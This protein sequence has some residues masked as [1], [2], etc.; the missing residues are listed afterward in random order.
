MHT[1]QSSKIAQL[2]AQSRGLIRGARTAVLST[3]M[4]SSQAPFGSLVLCATGPDGAPVL[5]LS[6]LAVHTLNLE[7]DPRACLLYDATGA[8]QAPL[9]GARLS[10]MGAIRP[11]PPDSLKFDKNRF[12]ARHPSAATYADFA[13]F[14]FYRMQPDRGH[15][16]AGFGQIGWVE[17]ADLLLKSDVWD[18]L[19]PAEA[20][21]LAHMN[22]DH[23]DSIALYAQKLLGQ[24]PGP[25]RMSGCDPE[26]CDLEMQGAF[27]RLAFGALVQ[28]PARARQ[29]LVRLSQLAR[30]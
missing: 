17:A 2:A 10:L 30:G 19:A 13:D 1:E 15:L 23:A 28:S 16:V 24:P 20:D 9:T 29:E 7:H 22:S 21:I 6:K 14:G 18:G 11:I 5:L 12:L 25:W 8:L 3:L 27:V 4:A 26:G